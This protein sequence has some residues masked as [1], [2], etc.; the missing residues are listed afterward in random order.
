MFAFIIRQY[1]ALLSGC[2]LRVNGS[3]ITKKPVMCNGRKIYWN[4]LN[5]NTWDHV[6]TFNLEIFTLTFLTSIMKIRWC[7]SV[8]HWNTQ[9]YH[10]KKLI[11]SMY[12]YVFN[13][14]LR[15]RNTSC[16]YFK[17]NFMWGIILLTSE[18]KACY[19]LS[20]TILRI[21]HKLIARMIN[22][23]FR[24]NDFTWFPNHVC[25]Y[26]STSLDKVF[27]MVYI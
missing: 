10:L 8:Y 13:F 27:K 1:L 23:N 6:D 7:H 26:Q 17:V 15:H 5:Y 18:V 11:D 20:L 19:N 16:A 9:K 2:Y 12:I 22:D 24:A 25:R 14:C 4:V 3:L 21:N